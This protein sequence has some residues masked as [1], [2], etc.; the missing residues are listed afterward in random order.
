MNRLIASI[1][2][3]LAVASVAAVTDVATADQT[4]ISVDGLFD[5]WN[6]VSVAWDDAFGDASGA[7]DFGSLQVTDDD[8]FLF[9]R[10]DV[11]NEFDLSENNSVRLYLDTD[12]DHTTGLSIEGIGAELEWRCGQRTGTFYYDGDETTV[13]HDDIRFRGDPAVTSD[14]F[15][16]A[17][18]RDTQPDGNNDLFTGT[19]VRILV[20][21]DNSGDMMPDAG[22]VVSYTLDVGN[23]PP[24]SPR[25]IQRLNPTH[26]RVMTHNVL[27][28]NLFDRNEEDAFERLYTAVDA[29]ILHLQEIYDHSANETRN[30]IAS[31][32]GGTW[33]AASVSDC[34]TVSRYPI[35]DS[36]A[37]DGNLAVLIDT[38]AAI[39]TEMLCIN[40]HLPCCDND[41]ARQDEADAIIAFVR[42]A[43]TPGGDLS[44]SANV[45]VMINGDLNLVGLARQLETLLTGD[46][47]DESSYGNDHAPDPDGSDLTSVVTRQTEKRMGYTWRSD[48]SSFWPGHLDYIMY[49]DSNIVRRHDFI[50]YTPEMTPAELAMY[51]LQ[52]GDSNASDH[53][54]FCADFKPRRQLFRAEPSK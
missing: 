39:G 23:A 47:Q 25:Q 35:V 42:D 16:I 30:Q 53:L 2:T 27:R 20:V 18:G 41:S 37:I 11:E 6:G 38:T 13:Y 19:L 17:I 3:V 12:G 28:D 1:T 7:V 21:D 54:V 45:P 31:W 4:P 52:A 5:D 29:D 9:L 8:R 22:N 10:L 48:S 14:R 43:Y 44:L 40:A 36:W 33:Y 51:G 15:E 24:P 46:I 34:K 26:L 49:S 50:I 32:L